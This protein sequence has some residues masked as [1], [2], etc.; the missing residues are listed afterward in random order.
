MT[1]PGVCLPEATLLSNVGKWK[2]LLNTPALQKSLVGG[3][4]SLFLESFAAQYPFLP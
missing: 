3:S 4:G 2:A 1:Q